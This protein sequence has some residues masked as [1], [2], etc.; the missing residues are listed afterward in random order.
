VLLSI[1][2][3]T[4]NRV[5]LL[6]QTVASALA[7]D[8]DDFELVIVDDASNDGTWEYL[9]GLSGV[10]AY[11]NPTRLGLAANW[12]RAISLSRGQYVFILQDDDLAEPGLVSTLAAEAGPELIC[13]AYCLIDADGGNPEMYW[14]SERRLLEPPAGLLE[15]AASVPFTS[16]QLLFQRAVFDRLGG[17]D[18]TFP[19]GSDAEMI[20]RW[21]LS[22]TALVIP[23]VLARKRRWEGSTSAAVQSTLAMSDTMRALVSS[24]SSQARHRLSSEQL[25]A[26]EDSLHA[27]FWVPYVFDNWRLA[28]EVAVQEVLQARLQ[29]QTE[30][31]EAT[32]RELERVRGELAAEVSA[33]AET[34]RELESARRA[35]A[36]EVAAHAETRHELESVY[37]STSWRVTSPMRGASRL[38]QRMGWRSV[39]RGAGRRTRA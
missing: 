23:D 7:Q 37:D 2:V 33:H 34:R 32:Q 35:I 13:F 29:Q 31:R 20:L 30:A 22:C 19:I 6:R 25:R 16:T 15:Y 17:M 11:R 26:L 5:G 24:I 12:N 28:R 38:A 36:A 18:E 39:S 3:P 27:S 10:R 14:Q 4:Y 1:V 9:R 8:S 21:L